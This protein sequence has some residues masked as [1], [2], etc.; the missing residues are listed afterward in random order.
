MSP[1]ILSAVAKYPWL[2]HVPRVLETGSEAGSVAGAGGDTGEAQYWG[3]MT[4]DFLNR[5]GRK[6]F[7]NK[8]MILQPL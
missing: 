7:P 2:W 3:T 8:D 4:P 6:L 5:S 1:E